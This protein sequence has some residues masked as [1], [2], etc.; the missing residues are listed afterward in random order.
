M[1]LDPAIE[2]GAEEELVALRDAA[3]LHLLPKEALIASI[4]D[5]A[6]MALALRARCAE[7][8]TE[9]A[10]LRSERDELRRAWKAS[11][12]LEGRDD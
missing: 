8:E 10:A 6:G 4:R 12:F 3:T 5:L 2:A 11:G 9:R 1:T 7:L